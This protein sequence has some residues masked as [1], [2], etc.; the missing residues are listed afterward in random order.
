MNRVSLRRRSPR[1]GVLERAARA[2]D[3]DEC[4]ARE[5]LAQ[6]R[7]GLR[8]AAQRGRLDSPQLNYVL[9]L[10]LCFF[11]KGLTSQLVLLAK[12]GNISSFLFLSRAIASFLHTNPSSLSGPEPPRS[13]RGPRRGEHSSAR[14][15]NRTSTF[16]AFHVFQK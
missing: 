13:A 12:D 4:E 15:G 11:G 5:H 1:L 9:Y 14:K 3:C 7:R 10:F 16:N 2:D 8:R 6:G